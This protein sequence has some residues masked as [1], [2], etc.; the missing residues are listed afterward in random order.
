LPPTVRGGLRARWRER[1]YG[2]ARVWFVIFTV[3]TVLVVVVASGGSVRALGRIQ[4]RRPWML[5]VGLA[6]QIVIEAMSF[7][8]HL[9]DSLGFALLMTSYV[10]ILGF[11]LLNLGIRGFGIIAIGVMMNTFVIAANH[12]MPAIDETVVLPSGRE[13]VRPVERTVKYRASTDDDV[14]HFLAD[15]IRFPAPFDSTTVSFGDLVLAVGLCDMAY[16]ASRRPRAERRGY[17]RSDSSPRRVRT[18]S[19]AASTRPS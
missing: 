10:L 1:D 19:R 17:G 11:C 16:H 8:E 5:G 9:V 3:L 7:P 6:L 2:R 13:V 14:A 4:L 12:G 18:R 15:I